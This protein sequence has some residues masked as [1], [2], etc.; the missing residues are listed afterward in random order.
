[1]TAILLQCALAAAQDA[2]FDSEA[3]AIQQNH[4][5]THGDNPLIA[6]SSCY[7]SL[8]D[9]Y[10]ARY[11]NCPPAD[12]LK[13][14]SLSSQG[15]WFTSAPPS[16]LEK[17]ADL[18]EKAK[19]YQIHPGLLDEHVKKQKERWYADSLTTLRLRSM[20]QDED[21]AAIAEQ[22]ER[23]T[24]GSAP[25][26]ELMTAVSTSLKKLSGSKS[27]PIDDLSRGLLAATNHT[28]RI[29]VLKE[30]LFATPS[31]PTDGSPSGEV[32][33]VHAKYYNMLAQDN[34]SMEQVKDA[35]LSDHQRL[36]SAQDEIKKVEAR[37]AEL[38]RGQA[39]Y[40]LEK[41]K[42][43]E[44]KRRLAEQQRSVIPDG[45]TNLPPCSV[46]RNPVNPS[47]FRLCTVCALLSGYELDGAE[48][49][50]YCGFEC[51]HEG[52]RNHL[53]A[54][55]CS[56]GPTC[57]HARVDSSGGRQIPNNNHAAHDEDTK[58]SD[59]LATPADV[60]FCKEC[61][62]NLKK[63]TAWCSPACVRAHYAQHHE[64]VHVGGAADGDDRMDTNGGLEGVDFDSQHYII[65][66]ADAVKEWEARNG[67]VRLEE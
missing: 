42:K 8:L 33:E 27:L 11:F 2:R 35:I 62:V 1:M 47:S 66:L 28:E 25:I 49:T 4:A 24:A 51:E 7:G 18:I 63:P 56:A 10:R 45:L 59:V 65:S 44:N 43:A 55:S 64:K 46:C 58:M 32:P 54:H 61:V 21:K 15:E 14:P 29:E 36:S 38:R 52:Y 12:L 34:A 5:A 6:C 67:G 50:V 60:R 17:L 40:E 39:A 20:V 57:V 22:L 37:L 3:S 26:E 30:A 23:F 53:K 16:F 19:Q 31:Q 9:L 13:D 48:M 41:A